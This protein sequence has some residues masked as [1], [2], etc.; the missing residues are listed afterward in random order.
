MDEFFELPEMAPIPD[1]ESLTIERARALLGGIEGNRDFTFVA[2][3]GKGEPTQRDIET[4][5]VDVATDGIPS[6]N[7]AGIRYRER[8][9]LKV[10]SATERPVEV[11]ALRKD[12]PLLP[13]QNQAVIGAPASLCLY[14]EPPK[15]VARTWTPQSFL[16][17]IQWWL[18]KSATAELHAADQ[19]VEQL[20]FVSPF[21]LVLPWNFDEMTA[22]S[23]QRFH[24]FRQEERP[25]GG[26]TCFLSAATDGKRSNTSGI[27][28]FQLSLPP[29]V[30]GRM[31]REP[32]SLGDLKDILSSRGGDLLTPLRSESQERVGPG[33]SKESD[34]SATILL[35]ETPIMRSEGGDPERI[36][37]RAY[38]IKDGALTLGKKIG[39]LFELDRTIYSAT[40]L[41][42][43]SE[44]TEWRNTLLFPMEVLRANT[45]KSARQQS[46]IAEPG[47]AAVLI[48]AGALG[49]ALINLW[50]R[51]G[52]G[53]WTVIDK[54]HVKPH[55]LSRHTAFHEHIGIQKALAVARL[56]NLMADGETRITALNA[57][58]CGRDR[59]QVIE[60]IRK[61][62]LVIDASTTLEFPRSSSALENVGRHISIFITPSGN[63]AVMLAEDPKRTMRLRTLEA[64][65]YRAILNAPW[66]ATHLPK[67]L[68][69]FWSGASCRDIS[70]VLP[71]SRIFAHSGTLA[72]QVQIASKKD[73]AAIRI[74]SHD[75][76]TGAVSAYSAPA[77]PER[78]LI[79]GAIDLYI[80]EG[81]AKKLQAI[82]ASMLPNETG[83][84]LLGYYDFNERF[85]ILVDA[86]HAPSDSTASPGHFER[87]ID[88]LKQNVEEASRRT[89]GIVG[90]VGEWHSHPRGHS[91]NPSH[92]D[93]RQLAHLA[94]ELA[95][96]GVP[97]IQLIVGEHDLN[98][99]AGWAK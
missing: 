32:N 28:L 81:L 35:L 72:E 77:F 64:Q 91:A 89:A 65:Y 66:G 61:A 31:E 4:I 30:Q 45:A 78:R 67:N 76:D 12:F 3:L 38:L 73:E 86:L 43:A 22:G 62:E 6:R 19:P 18:E 82:R 46:G 58:A 79:Q 15:V 27:A 16:R 39:A 42:S 69:N 23:G 11:L 96:D 93:V 25:D 36:Q 44:A 63:D 70:A 83:G 68:G 8:L 99:I 33:V 74:W 13:H 47:P 88:G 2:R 41:M 52:W 5:V 1:G 24:L 26:F 48:G 21:E 50:G 29:I 94:R 75:S 55:N 37:R 57:D 90:Y 56:H 9:A 92:A 34:S 60:A 71:Y 20:F 95:N 98:V 40:G 7:T 87:G 14:F 49:S 59:E 54:D 10:W 53:T 85:C 17:R 97:A 84:V 51:S 80:D